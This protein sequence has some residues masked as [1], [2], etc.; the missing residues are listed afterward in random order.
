MHWGR[1]SGYLP[2]K[3]VWFACIALLSILNLCTVNE[4]IRIFFQK[5]VN[6][7]KQNSNVVIAIRDQERFLTGRKGC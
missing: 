2:L 3:K 4:A 6:A 1:A 5:C 7:Q